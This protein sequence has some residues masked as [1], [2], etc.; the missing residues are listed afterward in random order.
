M[1]P[2][3]IPVNS[4]SRHIEPLKD[5]LAAAATE[6]VGSGYF[7]LGPNVRSFESA[8]ASYCGVD[9]CISVGNGTDA[10]ELSLR[11]LGVTA[12]DRLR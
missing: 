5:A 9:H 7:V 11:A 12:Q 8:F 6:V 1:P 3:A 10:L 4:L 2:E